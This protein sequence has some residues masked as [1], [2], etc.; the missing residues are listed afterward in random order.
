L[1][2]R[3]ICTNWRW[4]RHSVIS[5]FGSV[6]N[7]WNPDYIAGGSSGGSAAALAAGLCYV[8]IDTD[9]VG[10]CRLPASCCGVTGFKATYGL[11]S[12]K[13]ILEGEKADQTIIRLGHTAYM[14][15]T[16]E[17]AA[18][19]LNVLAD[20]KISQSEFRNDYSAAFGATK[21]PRIGIVKNFKATD[22]VRTHFLNAVEVF[23][24]LKYATSDINVPFESARFDIKTIEE[25]RK[26]ISKS[27]FGG[28]DVL[29]LPTTTETTPTI[30]EA[31]QREKSRAE[32]SVAFPADNTFFCNYYGLPAI[33]VPCGFSK[34][35]LPLGLQ[36]VGPQWGEGQ[37]LDIAH[38]YQNATEWHLRHPA[39]SD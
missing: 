38:R 24:S 4:E 16:V 8:T 30:E 20:S 10:S 34:N 21:N 9:A 22:E 7:P 1:W 18:V 5:H 13:G 14:T 19:L 29:V 33:T 27:L 35:G 3:R 31:G 2:E 26:V 37:V 17:G 12:T 6:H 36:I 11:L 25:D 32:N 23:R 15:R 39:A 28:F